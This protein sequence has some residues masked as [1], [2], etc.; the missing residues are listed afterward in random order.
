MIMVVRTLFNN[1]GFKAP[2]SRP[3]D[4]PLCA[5]CF[6]E[7]PIKGGP[8]FGIAPPKPTDEQCHGKC[9]EQKLCVDYRWG[10]TPK[11]RSFGKRAYPG[12]RVYLTYRQPNGNYTLWGKTTIQSIDDRVL[13][14][15]EGFGKG[16]VYAHLQPFQPLPREQWVRDLTDRE[17]VGEKWLMGRFRYCYDTQESHFE[18][19]LGGELVEKQAESP[20]VTPHPP[21]TVFSIALTS[22]IDEKLNKVAHD[23]GRQKEDI[24]RQAIAE[25]LRERGL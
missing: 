10:C 23:E 15:G 25:W 19:L 17:L 13:E 1:M 12:M 16:Y 6:K 4:D 7:D 21:T 14:S 22:H 18:R 5:P 11:G 3:R 8:L 2:C 9:W 24:V 20:H